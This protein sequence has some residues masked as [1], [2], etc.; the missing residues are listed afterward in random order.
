MGTAFLGVWLTKH[1]SSGESSGWLKRLESS[2]DFFEQRGWG[3]D[4]EGGEEADKS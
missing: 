4:G 3:V 1:I 2:G